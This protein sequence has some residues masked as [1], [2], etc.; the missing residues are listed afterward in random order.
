MPQD[1]HKELCSKNK[2][3]KPPPMTWDEVMNYITLEK[4]AHFPYIPEVETV[5]V[6]GEVL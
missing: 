1:E 5:E 4:D 2:K 6:E 3:F